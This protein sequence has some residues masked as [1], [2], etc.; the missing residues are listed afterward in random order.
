MM[1][2]NSHVNMDNM[3]ISLEDAVQLVRGK[4]VSTPVKQL[5]WLEKLVG[6]PVY[7]KM[8]FHQHTG[9]FKYRGAL[10]ALAHRRSDVIIAASAGN[11]GVAVATVAK[12]L[13]I[14]AKIVLPANA[15]R[16]KRDKLSY[17]DAE[18]LEYGDSLG[19]AG[20]YARSLAT[21]YGWDYISAFNDRRVI[22][23]NATLTAEVL[24]QT[25]DARTLIVPVGGGGLL[26][27]AIQAKDQLGHPVRLHG[28]E[29]ENYASVSQG[30]G[31]AR[32]QRVVNQPTFA[33]GLAVQLTDEENSLLE[34]MSARVEIDT[35]TEEQIAMGTVSLLQ[36]E[37]WLVE[38]S[39]AICVAALLK[40]AERGPLDGPVVLLLSGGN[41]Q[42]STV[43]RLISY[44]FK[45][46]SHDGLLGLASDRVDAIDATS[47]FEL[48]ED[49]V[50]SANVPVQDRF[51]L[52][53][54]LENYQRRVVEF[55]QALDDY[56]AFCTLR[57]LARPLPLEQLAK[58][59]LDRTDVALHAA[60]LD[61]KG[62]GIVDEFVQ[63]STLRGANIVLSAIRLMFEWRSAS[64]D[65]SITPQFFSLGHQ[66]SPNANY[67]RYQNRAAS[68]M[69]VQLR[70]VMGVRH[71]NIGCTVTSSGMAA[72]STIEAFLVRYRLKPDDVVALAP[73]IY[74]EADEQ[75]V[76]LPG[77]RTHRLS[78]YDAEQMADE[79]IETNAS[80]VFVD[81][82]ANIAEL[83]TCDVSRLVSLLNSRA[84]RHVTIVVDGTMASAQLPRLLYTEENV[85]SPLIDVI[86]YES[87]S[88][89]LQLGFE[90]SLAGLILHN[91]ARRPHFDRMR[92][93]IGS[94]IYAAEADLF[95]RFGRE[96][97][98]RH[99]AKIERSATNM[100]VVLVSHD[101]I[102]SQLQ[103]CYPRQQDHVDAAAASTLGFVGGCLC[104]KFR[105]DGLNTQ[106]SLNAFISLTIEHARRLD[107]VLVKGVSF[108]FSIP[109]LSAAS[110]MAEGQRPFLRLYAGLLS[111]V[112]A[113]KLG[114]A[115]SRAIKQFVRG[116]G[117]EHVA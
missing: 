46:N 76:S 7:A 98:L 114:A 89:Y 12:A 62:N 57:K 43:A 64:Y 47:H 117:A 21:T 53:N 31:L 61:T 102:A 19:D 34:L 20:R 8:E 91:V 37:S 23:G 104:L 27:G 26:L 72:Y 36:K 51:Y 94:I 73:Y 92:R 100:A 18:I 24:A 116:R 93:N 59:V 32:A 108:G 85:S 88:K 28:A 80:V 77:I 71:S 40:L 79:I 90:Y 3:T 39:G 5:P 1:I 69:E 82:I 56:Q 112:E 83:R 63:M 106:D 95:P 103:V 97:Y 33:D 96:S 101:A 107:C 11:H 52:D 2:F 17:L 115:F 42:K 49:A 55:N 70:E 14:K 25:P 99:L 30:L 60:L 86:Y 48:P 16:L 110:S 105:D 15:S 74:F 113:G 78:S 10:C 58:D 75:I 29:P 81:P 22:S 109:R 66:E 65:Q 50:D 111:D 68:E 9:S 35:L 38:P 87:C 41:V 67:D 54:A 84:R 13:G 45:E 44:P 6:V 4:A